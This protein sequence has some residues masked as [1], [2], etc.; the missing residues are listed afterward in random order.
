MRTKIFFA[1]MATV[2]SMSSCE[3]LS[4]SKNATISY[5]LDGKWQVDSLTEG[6]DSTSILPLLLAL[7]AS[8]SNNNVS[9]QLHFISDTVITTYAGGKSDTSFFTNDTL[10]KVIYIKEDS[11]N[12][13]IRYEFVKDNQLFLQLKDSSVLHLSRK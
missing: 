13:K 11:T 6:N 10:A 1:L 7:S 2:I 9:M 12:E 3:W 4:P 5:Q 8:D